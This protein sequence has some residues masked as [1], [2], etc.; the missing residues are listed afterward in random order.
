MVQGTALPG[1]S[2]SPVTKV[3]VNKVPATLAADGSFSAT[4]DVPAGATMLETVAISS[5]GGSAT[6]ARTVHAG[7]LRP[8]GAN[9]ERAITA[10]LSK[11][12]FARLSKAADEKIKTIDLS[13]LLA[14]QQPVANLG[15][16]LANLK[17]S[18]TSLNLGTTKI[19]LTPVDGGLE[20][21]AE[22]GPLNVAAKAAYAGTFVPDGTTT[23]GVTADKITVTGKLVVT[24]NG[25]NGFTTKITSPS[26]QTTALKLQASGLA[27]SILDLMTDNL[28]STV[29]RIITSSAESALEPMLNQALGALAGPQRIAVMGKMLEIEASPNTIT[30]SRDGALVTMN[31]KAKLAGSEVSPGFIFTPN[32]TPTMNVGSG[33]HLGLADDLINEMLAEVHALG[34]LDIHIEDNFGL[35][36]VADIKLAAPPMIS[37]NNDDGAMR[38]VLGDMIA[39]FTDHGKPLLKAA[40]NASVDLEIQRGTTAQ[41]IALQFGKVRAF[42]NILDDSEAAAG[43]DL[44]GAATAGIGIQ[45]DKLSKFLITVPIPSVAGVTL[46]SLALRADNGYVVVSGDVH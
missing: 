6:D 8:V 27:G 24:P 21:S 17:V 46:D 22:I 32:G 45:L 19:S 14:S 16:S 37:A 30:F 5:E 18:I 29:Q 25:T 35:F 12:A 43:D 7:E 26:V 33:I 3:S 40:V 9:I 11:D 20:L 13:Q 23:V 41:E 39:T 36:D 2:G 31:I 4:I 44:S 42:V 38:L 28:G 15:D 1:P 10:S 34:L